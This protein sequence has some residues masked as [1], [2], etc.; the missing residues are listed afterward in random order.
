MP[1]CRL[2]VSIRKVLRPAISTQVFPSQA[3]PSQAKVLTG[4]GDLREAQVDVH[5][6]AISAFDRTAG[7]SNRHLNSNRG[8]RH[9]F[10]LVSLCLKA[11]AEMVPKIPS[12]HY[13][14]LMQPFRLELSSN[15]FH[16]LY[17]CKI[18]NA[19]G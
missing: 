19:T 15:Q 17:A 8:L 7:L 5:L 2:E 9:R 16:I 6:S 14:L 10:F 12:C 11:S 4:G 13:M 1:D 3:K 18:T